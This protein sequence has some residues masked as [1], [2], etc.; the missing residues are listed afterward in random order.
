MSTV[1][2]IVQKKSQLLTAGLSVEHS[3]QAVKKVITLPVFK[4]VVRM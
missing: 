3:V 1:Q 2:K 4:I